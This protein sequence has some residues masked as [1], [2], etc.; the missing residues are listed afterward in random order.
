[1]IKQNE[2]E[3]KYELNIEKKE[4]RYKKIKSNF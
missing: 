1:M 3:K 4:A 2:K